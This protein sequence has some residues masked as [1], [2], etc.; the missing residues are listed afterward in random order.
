MISLLIS[1]G[2]L[3]IS[4]ESFNVGIRKSSADQIIMATPSEYFKAAI[5]LVDDKE[6]PTL[7][8][9]QDKLESSLRK[10]YSNLNNYLSSFNINFYYFSP[11]EKSMCL[12]DKCE[13]VEICISG[14]IDYIFPYHKTLSYQITKRLKT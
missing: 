12:G 1:F 6:E 7:Y 4:F 13:G 8:F 11:S 5:P 2:V 10:Y 9:N 14:D 3:L